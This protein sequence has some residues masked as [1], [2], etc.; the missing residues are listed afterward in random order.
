[1]SSGYI[2]ALF[3]GIAISWIISPS[4]STVDGQRWSRWLASI[5]VFI[6][7]ISQ[8]WRVTSPAPHGGINAIGTWI[9]ITVVLGFAFYLLGLIAYALINGVKKLSK[10][11]IPNAKEIAK[12]GVDSVKKKTLSGTKNCPFC[13]EAI[14]KNAIFCRFCKNNLPENIDITSTQSNH[15]PV[16]FSVVAGGAESIPSGFPETLNNAIRS[17]IAAIAPPAK[18]FAERRG[19]LHLLIVSGSSDAQ[20]LNETVPQGIALLAADERPQIVHQASEKNIEALKAS[21]AAV[22]VQAHCVGFIED[23]ADAYEWA[24]LVICRSDTLAVAELA[25]AGVASILV[26][27]PH[28]VDENQTANAKLLVNTGGAFLLPQ[29]EL[30]PAAIAVIRNFS[31]GQLLEMAEKAHSLTKI[32]D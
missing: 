32:N 20:L 14:K 1:M 13:A 3:V 10:I 16:N 2:I 17:K 31:R 24:D 21:Y 4:K 5:G 12:T 22:G 29:H 30:T 8:L 28:A 7:T 6:A 26:P 19:A 9:L 23:M 25:A 15:T 18:R 27:F 11:A